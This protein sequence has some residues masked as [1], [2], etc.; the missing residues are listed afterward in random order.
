MRF[1]NREIIK[2]LLVPLRAKDFDTNS[3]QGFEEMDKALS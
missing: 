2:G 3:K 1:I